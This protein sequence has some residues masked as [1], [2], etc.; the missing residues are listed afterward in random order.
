VV[1]H[2][3]TCH[4]HGTTNKQQTKKSVSQT[5]ETHFLREPPYPTRRAGCSWKCR[6]RG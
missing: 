1:Q 5:P 6:T 2:D 4:R 3:R